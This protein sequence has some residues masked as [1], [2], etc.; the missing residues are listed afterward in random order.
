[1]EIM[2]RNR[3][4]RSRRCESVSASPFR[5][6]IPAAMLAKPLPT[7]HGN[8]P[9]RGFRTEIPTL[10]VRRRKTASNPSSIQSVFA[11][12]RTKSEGIVRE[13]R[14]TA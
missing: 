5:S 4:S 12:G 9:S 2:A 8:G 7:R 1:M 3:D 6:G 14:L 10:Y 13:Y 11:A